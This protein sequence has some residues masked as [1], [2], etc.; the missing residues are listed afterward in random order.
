MHPTQTAATVNHCFLIYFTTVYQRLD[1]YV[2]MDTIS[3]MT[4]SDQLQ[5]LFSNIL[6]S[7]TLSLERLLAMEEEVSG[8]YHAKQY[9]VLDLIFQ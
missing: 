8:E 6:H 2:V 1:L 3:C 5:I 4:S 7:I 9:S